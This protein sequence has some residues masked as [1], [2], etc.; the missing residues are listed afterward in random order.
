MENYMSNKFLPNALLSSVIALGLVGCGGS[1]NN[2]TQGQNNDPGLV[3]PIITVNVSGSVSAINGAV[4]FYNPTVMDSFFASLLGKQLHASV[5]G[6]SSVGAGVD[7]HLIKVD[8]TGLQIG[9]A[10]A[11]AVTDANGHYS[12]DA[13]EGFSPSSNYVL[14]AAGQSDSIQARVTSLTQDI[15]SISDASHSIIA[16]NAMELGKLSTDEITEIHA[17][18]SDIVE[19]TDSNALNIADFRSAIIQ[20]ANQNETA[21]NVISSTIAAGTICGQVTDSDNLALQNIRIVVSDFG[22]WVTRAKTSTDANGNY[23]VNV[24]LT[25]DPDQYI[26]GRVHTGEYILGAINYTESS[27]AA[28]QWW[29]SSST[30]IDGSGG[31]N[32]QSRAEKVSVN[33]ATLESHDFVLD[34]NG[35][36]ITGTVFGDSDN[37]SIG[38]VAVDGMRVLIRNYD[39][40]KPLASAK[41]GVDGRYVINVK[42]FDYMLSFRN[43]SRHPFASEVYRDQTDGV[44]NRNFASRESMNANETNRY[45]AILKPG[46]IISGKVLDNDANAVAGEQVRIDNADGGR[47]DVLRTNKNGE[48][49]IW[50]DPRTDS[51]LPSPYI[52]HSRGQSIAVD[53]NGADDQ[54]ATG[55]KLS[56]ST[57]VV[58]DAQTWK[59]TGRLI[60]SDA[61]NTAVPGNI[62]RF[63]A[64]PKGIF[65]SGSDGSFTLYKLKTGA[66]TTAD[67]VR[68]RMDDFQLYG[69]GVLN[70]ETKTIDKMPIWLGKTIV[71]DATDI[72]L[73]ELTVPTLNQG[74]GVGYI[75]GNTANIGNVLVKIATDNKVMV[76]YGARGDGSFKMTLPSGTYSSIFAVINKTNV[77]CTNV[78]I[79]NNETVTLDFDSINMTCQVM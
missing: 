66:P 54:T 33:T 47:I 63:N 70:T 16:D 10:I 26:A 14:S 74:S 12:I 7:V 52:L 60:S 13:P 68:L 44:N 32:S 25:G 30:N 20:G 42:A 50:V 51:M 19:S 3:D 73:G 59:L 11:T 55:F 43:K 23:C 2:D 24:P 31:A 29:T 46:V 15:D 28:S 58:L 27:Y 72:D 49:Q 71:F 36:R 61:S 4:A 57:H 22:N 38:D 18:V 1:N 75:Q 78:T 77:A 6:E 76:V 79:N 65:V 5:A 37:D 17:V 34:K 35:A 45:D 67:A 39:S 64:N 56:D 41:V 48:F 69:S 62:L 9:D 53:T 21:N 40:F 8:N